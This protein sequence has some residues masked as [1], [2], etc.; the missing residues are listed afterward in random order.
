MRAE[1]GGSN[2]AGGQG[3]HAFAGSGEALVRRKRHLGYVQSNIQTLMTNISAKCTTPP[4]IL[5]IIEPGRG[6][7]TSP[8]EP[9]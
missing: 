8:L 3:T 2:A 4:T 6:D 5:I 9:Y 1:Y 7:T